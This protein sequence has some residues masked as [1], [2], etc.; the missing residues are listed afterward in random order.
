M[1]TTFTFLSLF[2]A[3]IIFGQTKLLKQY[4]EAVGL[5]EAGKVEKAYT[6]FKKI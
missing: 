2:L 4:E 5:L 1:R 3:F 6:A